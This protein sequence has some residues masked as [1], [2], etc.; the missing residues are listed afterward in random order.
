MIYEQHG[1]C[2]SLIIGHSSYHSATPVASSSCITEQ[3]NTAALLTRQH[4]GGAGVE[5]SAG[6]T[7]TGQTPQYPTWV[8][9][10]RIENAAWTCTMSL[11]NPRE[12]VTCQRTTCMAVGNITQMQIGQTRWGQLGVQILQELR[13]GGSGTP[14]APKDPLLYL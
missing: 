13:L 5:A 10:P 6:Q 2:N 1:V 3:Q 4:I 12:P 14:P 7:A 8:A 11:T 9:A